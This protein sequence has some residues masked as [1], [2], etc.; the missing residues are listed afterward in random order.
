MNNLFTAVV[1]DMLEDEHGAVKAGAND[2][3][4]DYLE[5]EAEQDVLAYHLRRSDYADLEDLRR[6]VRERQS[7]DFPTGGEDGG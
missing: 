5:R 7:A 1:R 2:A 6:A 4:L 3:L